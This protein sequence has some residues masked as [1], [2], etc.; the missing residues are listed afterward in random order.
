[1][2]RLKRDLAVFSGHRRGRSPIQ[3]T[4]PTRG[5]GRSGTVWRR[6][7]DLGR[8]Y[9]RDGLAMSPP[10]ATALSAGSS[11]QKLSHKEARASALQ[12]QAARYVQTRLAR[13]QN[14]TPNS[15][16]LRGAAKTFSR[17]AENRRTKWT[18]TGPRRTTLTG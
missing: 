5:D 6:E 13:T 15:R 10:R 9:L 7:A 16:L 12:A 8:G 18:P 17:A 1:M 14:S 2:T 4:A 3:R 11:E